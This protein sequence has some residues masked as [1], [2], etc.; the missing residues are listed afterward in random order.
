VPENNTHFEQVPIAI[1]LEIVEKQIRRE[2]AAAADQEAQERILL[3]LAQ[4]V[5]RK[6]VAKARI[7]SLEAGKLS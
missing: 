2:Q 5:N 4:E 7:F 1:V 3:E 6:S